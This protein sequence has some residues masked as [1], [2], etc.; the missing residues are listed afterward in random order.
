ME[1]AG[2]IKAE[3]GSF[4]VGN[5][6]LNDFTQL[7]HWTQQSFDAYKLCLKMLCSSWETQWLAGDQQSRGHGSPDGPERPEE[8]SCPSPAGSKGSW[9]AGSL[10]VCVCD[11]VGE[12]E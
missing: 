9:T 5:A 4:E 2:V 1:S 10:R 12:R 3:W 7:G 11:C 6:R 8:E